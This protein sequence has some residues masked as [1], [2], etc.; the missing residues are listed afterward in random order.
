MTLFEHADGAPPLTHEEQ[1]ALI[2]D[3]STKEELNEWELQNIVAA[4]AWALA[5]LQLAR[6]N[7]FTEAYVRNLHKRMFD[8]TWKWAGRYRTAEKNIGIPH[9]QIRDALG[10]LLGNSRFWVQ[11][12]TFEPDEIAIRLHHQLV[13]IHP[14]PNGN[15]RHARLF[16]DVVARVQGRPVFSW[17]GASIGQ[18]GELRRTYIEALRSADQGNLQKLLVFG[19]A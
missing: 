15:G 18:P 2:P 3:L 9:Y 17:G 6:Q 4:R 13:Y 7:P 1:V 11:H 16:A 14:F 12:A 10:V 8:Q 5:P 19:R